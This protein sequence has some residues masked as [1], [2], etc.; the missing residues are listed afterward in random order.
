VA[1][2]RA[3]AIKPD[4]AAAFMNKGFTLLS[5]G[6]FAE[7]WELMDRRWRANNADRRP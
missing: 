3:I 1:Y 7:G 5:Q 4:L 2:E 6:R